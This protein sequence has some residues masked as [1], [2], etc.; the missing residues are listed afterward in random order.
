MIVCDS[1]LRCE[2]WEEFEGKLI[3]FTSFSEYKTKRALMATWKYCPWC[4]KERFWDKDG[5]HEEAE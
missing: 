3:E 4:G 5:W 1:V 2:G